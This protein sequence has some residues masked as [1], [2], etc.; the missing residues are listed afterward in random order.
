MLKWVVTGRRRSVDTVL[1]DDAS[2]VSVRTID[3]GSDSDEKPAEPGVSDHEN[4]ADINKLIKEINDDKEDKESGVFADDLQDHIDTLEEKLLMRNN[5][6]STELHD[7]E[8][9]RNAESDL[10]QILRLSVED[11]D[12]SG[13]AVVEDTDDS[14]EMGGLSRQRFSRRAFIRKVGAL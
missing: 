1:S 7:R 10:L 12:G 3:S 4:Q 13:G 14:E 2:D 5:N 6:N 8:L 11:G 9:L